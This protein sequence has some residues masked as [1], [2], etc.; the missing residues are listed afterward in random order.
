VS[1][2]KAPGFLT[3]VLE[4]TSNMLISQLARMKNKITVFYHH[5]SHPLVEINDL[6]NFC[7]LEGFCKMVYFGSDSVVVIS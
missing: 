5:I 2:F 4:P 1:F 3:L 6:W 7:N